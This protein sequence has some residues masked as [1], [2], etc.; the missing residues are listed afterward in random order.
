MKLRRKRRFRGAGRS[1]LTDFRRQRRQNLL[2]DWRDFTVLTLLI[3][4]FAVVS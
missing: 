4:T 2:A 3:P 1:G